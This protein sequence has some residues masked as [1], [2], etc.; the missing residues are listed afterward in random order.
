MIMRTI[1]FIFA[2]F[3]T[4]F[5]LF[6]A[7]AS[8][9]T[10]IDARCYANCKVSANSPAEYAQCVSSAANEADSTLNEALGDLQETIV[11]DAESNNRSPKTQLANLKTAQSKWTAY[12]DADCTL[13]GSLASDSSDGMNKASTIAA[14]RCALAYQRAR[15]FA[16]IRE[17][18]IGE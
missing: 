3:V 2:L 17:N 13:Q 12:R 5:L 1:G 7:L 16:R 18:V 15:D 11:N 6:P 4:P 10:D 14:C 8:A 9:Q